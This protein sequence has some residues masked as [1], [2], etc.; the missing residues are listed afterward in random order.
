MEGMEVVTLT[1]ADL[2]G[3]LTLRTHV[4]YILREAE[5]Y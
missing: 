3:K 5:I 4:S 2:T 1:Y